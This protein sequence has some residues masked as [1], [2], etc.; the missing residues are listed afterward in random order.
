MH[1]ALTV[2]AAFLG[3]ASAVLPTHPRDPAH[4]QADAVVNMHRPYTINWDPVKYIYQM[5]QP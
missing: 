3:I 5:Y 4:P 2:I 1:L